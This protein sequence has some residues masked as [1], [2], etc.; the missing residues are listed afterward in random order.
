MTNTE[1]RSLTPDEQHRVLLDHVH[2]GL[3]DPVHHPQFLIGVLGCAL[4]AIAYVLFVRRG[5]ADEIYTLPLL[6]ICLNIT[7]EALAVFVIPNPIAIWSVLEWTWLSIDVVLLTLL[8]VYGRAQQRIPEIQ[9]HFYPIV[10]LVLAMCFVA[11]WSFVVTFGDPL[12]FMVA[13]MINLVM[14]ILFVFLYFER[15]EDMRGLS[16]GAAWLKLLGTGCTSIQSAT[17]L[18]ALRP[19]ITSWSWMHFLYISIFGFDSLYVY[20]LHRRRTAL[21][22]NPLASA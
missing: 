1:P 2:Q 11:Q 17:L 21:R 13:F 19:D 16:I 7:W 5:L 12:G 22:S 6:A 10:A 3:T 9:R 18:P 14:S 15:R 20:L 4:W 8:L